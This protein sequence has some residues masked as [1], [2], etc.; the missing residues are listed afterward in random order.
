VA[1]NARFHQ[2]TGRSM[3]AAA[4]H[5]WMAAK[6]AFEVALRS[7]AGEDDL[8]ALRFDGH[9]GQPL[10]FSEDGHLVQ[11]TCRMMDGRATLAPPVSHDLLMDAD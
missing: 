7:D 3:D 11:P 9:K 4:W 6:V 8:L 1:L 10:R 2:R 5:G